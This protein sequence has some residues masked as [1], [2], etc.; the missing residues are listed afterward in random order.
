MKKIFLIVS[1][2]FCAFV[3]FAQAP[4]FIL[5]TRSSPAITV[6]DAHWRALLTAYMPHTHGLTL[7]GGLD[8]LGAFIYEDSSRHVWYRDSVLA[9]GHKWTMIL[10]QND[11]A[12]TGLIQQGTNVTITG[13]GTIVS[14]YI[15]NSTGGGGGG[16][17]QFTFTDGNGFTGTVLNGTGPTVN[18]SLG[19]S[20][21]GMLRGTGTALATVTIGA[22]LS[23]IGGTLTNT[24]NNTN[25]L[26]NGALFL[27]NIT[28]LVSA[29]TNITITG[30]G[31]PG[32]PYVI[33]S[34]GGGVGITG[35]G[36]LTPLF[37]TS[38]ISNTLNF[39]L[40]NANAHTFF[41]NFTGSSGA[42]S[43]GSPLLTAD[44]LNQG[45]T[46]TVLHGNAAGA[47]T[48]SAINLSADVTNVLAA[49]NGGTG[50]SSYT[51]GD[52][53]Y[54]SSTTAL[55]KLADVGTGNVLLSGG[56]G[57]APLWGKVN[58]ATAVTG[59]LPIGNIDTANI[60]F[61]T[62]I[63]VR[64]L[65]TV[66]DS[67]A[68]VIGGN[69]LGFRRVFFS[70][71]S[72]VTHNADSS[73]TIT[74]AGGGTAGYLSTR[75]TV[76]KTSH[77]FVVGDIV[78]VDSTVT[79]YP[80][81][82]A[83]ANTSTI[84]AR[85]V[86]SKVIDANNF[87]YTSHGPMDWAGGFTLNREVYSHASTAGAG[88]TTPPIKNIPIGFQKTSGVFVVD[89]QRGFDFSGGG[90]GGS[91]TLS[92]VSITS[93]SSSTAV[94]NTLYTFN[95]AST[96]ASYTFTLPPSPTDQQVV[97]IESGGTITSGTIVT[98]LSVL[99]NTAQDIIQSSTPVTLTLGEGWGYRWNS[100][101]SK[102][103]RYAK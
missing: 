23:F 59:I 92:R 73:L 65:G 53:L 35:A 21:T 4:P 40:S 81:A 25:Q 90:G 9:G 88:T 29:G 61:H 70:T 32:N 77:G 79:T 84:I 26:T 67:L 58:L 60:F 28:G 10:T 24:I 95:P 3:S 94:V 15:I 36:N 57:V 31:T 87:I 22:G 97:E 102:W 43:Y 48:F 2:L 17:S 83:K 63:S 103:Y 34:S 13:A 75:D 82:W 45:T 96:L 49:I 16:I 50:F 74:F 78:G 52:I 85:G 86:V 8:T 71:G 56:V 44:F 30:N 76:V 12:I 6:Q 98:T 33:N 93:G 41:G 101:V 89:L 38:I 100:T 99:P 66:G 5:P 37:T 47:L 1:F 80:A 91:S 20:I 11:V 69:T 55:S 68:Y 19:T 54:A 7:N 18:L 62:S 39:N 72:T 14:P 27:Q 42:P 64:N 51:V 46:T